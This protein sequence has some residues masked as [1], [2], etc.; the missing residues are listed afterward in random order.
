MCGYFFQGIIST[1]PLKAEDLKAFLG[2]SVHTSSSCRLC[3]CK[4]D[5][6]FETADRKKLRFPPE[7][8]WEGEASVSGCFVCLG[9]QMG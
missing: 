7:V 9:L 5:G 8:T 4:V 2:R 3:T 6:W 1:N